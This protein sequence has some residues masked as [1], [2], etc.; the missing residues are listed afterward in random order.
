MKQVVKIEKF[1]MQF[2]RD[3]FLVV[4]CLNFTGFQK[5]DTACLRIATQNRNPLDDC[6]A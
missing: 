3:S 1:T 2:I 4:T 6:N 5:R